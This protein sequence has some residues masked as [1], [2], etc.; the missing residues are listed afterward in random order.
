MQ[1][2]AKSFQRVLVFRQFYCQVQKLNEIVRRVLRIHRVQ[3]EVLYALFE[4]VKNRMTSEI[5]L[6]NAKATSSST[7]KDAL[8]N[9]ILERL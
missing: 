3:N 1:D 9:D 2:Q 6:A 5:M 7:K 8:Y 4:K